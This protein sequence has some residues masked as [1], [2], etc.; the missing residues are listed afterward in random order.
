LPAGVVSIKIKYFLHLL[1]IFFL[2][3]LTQVGGILWLFYLIGLRR[4]RPIWKRWQ[5]LSGFVAAY[6]FVV[7]IVVP[8]LAPLFGRVAL[9]M[10]GAVA[11]RTVFTVLANRHYLCTRGAE[12]L[13]KAAANFQKKYPNLQVLYLDACFPFWDGFPLLPHLSHDDGRKLD[14]A[15]VYTRDGTL[16][17]AKPA[18]SGYGAY[19]EPTAGKSDQNAT[20]KARGYWQYD[21]PKYLT[22]GVNKQ[23]EFAP[24]A[25]ADLIRALLALPIT[26]KILLEPHLRQRM[27]LPRAKVR[28][29]GCNS[30][31]HDDHIHWQF[32]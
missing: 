10:G 6:L 20:C 30:V 5:K 21:F 9:P 8:Q 18:R 31:R 22:F 28:F 2:T 1:V 7:L 12:N 11:P 3:V 19:V 16:T 24:R 4:W 26:D 14:L 32:R 15:F 17:N 27:R 13:A 29:Q 23:L 25:T